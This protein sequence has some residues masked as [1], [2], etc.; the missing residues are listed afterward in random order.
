M[1][2]FGQALTCRADINI[3]LCVVDKVLLDE[4][5][6]FEITRCKRLGHIGGDACVGALKQLFAA[7]ISSICDDRD[8][9]AAN[10]QARLV[11]H[12]HQL[13]SITAR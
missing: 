1:G 10:C 13:P 2:T 12:L 6:S 11:G 7:V 9:F 8:L 5:P 3:V 4:N